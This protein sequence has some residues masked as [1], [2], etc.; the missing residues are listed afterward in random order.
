ML[1]L[2]S[3]GYKVTAICHHHCI[4]GYGI[5]DYTYNYHNICIYIDKHVL[6]LTY[7]PVVVLEEH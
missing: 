5:Y 7:P 3:F 2:K 1:F 6:Q 4:H